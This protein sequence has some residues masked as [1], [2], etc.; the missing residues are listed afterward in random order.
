MAVTFV[1]SLVS[2]VALA[3]L[4]AC[5]SAPRAPEMAQPVAQVA[6]HQE[7]VP[8]PPLPSPSP[9]FRH[10]EVAPP[11]D[12]GR[13]VVA[14]PRQELTDAP[15]AGVPEPRLMPMPAVAGAQVEET[16]ASQGPLAEDGPVG[17]PQTPTGFAIPDRPEVSGVLDEFCG[18]RSRSFAEA[19]RRGERYL[20]MIRSI[21]AEKGLPEELAYVALVESSFQP[22]AR[23]SADAVG[24]WQFIESTARASGLRVD[25]W[26]DER[27]DPEAATRAAARHLDELFARF[28]DWDL[29]LAAYNAGPNGV[30][31]ALA[32]QEAGGF[33]TLVEAGALRAETRRY[34]P[35]FYAAIQVARDPEAYGFSPISGVAPVRYETVEVDAPVDLATA[36]R[37]VDATRRTLQELNPALKRGCTPPGGPYPLHVPEG[38]SVRLA[39]GLAALPPAQRVTF[40]RYRLRPGDTLWELSRRHGTPVQAIAELNGITDARRLRPGQELAVP[41]PATR[42]ARK[43]PPGEC[44]PTVVDRGRPAHVVEPG[45]TVWSIARDRGLDPREVL[46][47]NG[48]GERSLLRPGDRLFLAPSGSGHPLEVG[49]RRVHIVR[50]GENL[51]AISRRYGVP[52]SKLMERNGLAPSSVLRPGD[53]LLVGAGSAGSGPS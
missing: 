49:A 40:Q 9:P 35:K 15:P 17:E 22:H 38:T 42:P 10:H 2:A 4:A 7:P 5:A 3:A 12:A 41:V 14:A 47:W 18:L 50:A 37:L 44:L 13:D 34:V 28:G 43:A 30:D 6:P 33:W 32:R 46:R 53:V 21:L 45:D 51:W 29:A 8:A 24:L 19:L 16:Q 25:W 27:L 26:V 36:A 39:R 11:L 20:P 1:R 48:L 31:R 52:L 23:S